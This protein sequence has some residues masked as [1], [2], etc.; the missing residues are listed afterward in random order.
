MAPKIQLAL[1]PFAFV[2][3]G[4]CGMI[5]EETTG[6]QVEAALLAAILDDP[7]DKP[8]IPVYMGIPKFGIAPCILW[9]WRKKQLK[10]AYARGDEDS[11]QQ[12]DSANQKKN[13]KVKNAT[14][15]KGKHKDLEMVEME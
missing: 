3:D 5:D 13:A 10:D 2:L 8:L 9:F 14:G 4:F 11:D 12:K 15:K 7:P 6:P 1:T